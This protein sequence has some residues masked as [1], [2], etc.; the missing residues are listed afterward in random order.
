LIGVV[1]GLAGAGLGACV[2]LVALAWHRAG[3]DIAPLATADGTAEQGVVQPP[4]A[5]STSGLAASG[6]RGVDC[7]RQAWPYVSESCRASVF[8]VQEGAGPERRVRVVGLDTNAPPVISMPAPTE[9]QARRQASVPATRDAARAERSQIAQEPSTSGGSARAAAAAAQARRMPSAVEPSAIPP[10]AAVPAAKPAP[11]AVEDS[12]HAEAAAGDGDAA[13]TGKTM[14]TTPKA[15]KAKRSVAR[16][17]RRR[18][19]AFKTP[20]TIVR[21]IEFA[22]GRRV[23][24]T[25]PVGRESVASAM[26]AVDR[27]AQRALDRAPA[28]SDAHATDSGFDPDVE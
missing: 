6:V 5:L 1:W 20:G 4:V 15:G 3:V 16:S 26:A 11:S 8:G 17:D 18:D 14:A 24:I 10:A 12:R 25:R 9:L 23:T 2:L 28:G 13:P 7:T 19:D 27:A 22:D 21:T